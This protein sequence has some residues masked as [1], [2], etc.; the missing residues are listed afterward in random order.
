MCVCV[1]VC[2]CCIGTS[3]ATDKILPFLVEIFVQY[4]AHWWIL[5]HKCAYMCVEIWWCRVCRRSTSRERLC[6]MF[7]F[8]STCS[9]KC[10]LSVYCA[11]HW[12][13]EGPINGK[14]AQTNLWTGCIT[15]G[16]VDLL[17]LFN[18]AQAPDCVSDQPLGM[19]L[20]GMQENPNIVLEN[21]CS[22]GRSGLIH[23]SL[24]LHESSSPC[25]K[26]ASYQPFLQGFYGF[27]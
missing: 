10:S 27:D 24:G 21:C 9:S 15:G 19:L 17:W 22:P 18:A 6:R 14:I 12:N 11:H 1:C 3:D 20:C 5:S 7:R 23:V 13:F 2:V 26:M 25:P 8:P 16:G 4:I